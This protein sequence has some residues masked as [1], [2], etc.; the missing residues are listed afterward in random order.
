MRTSMHERRLDAI[1]KKIFFSAKTCAC[2][3]DTVKG[4]EMWFVNRWAGSG[5]CTWYYC[6]KCMKTKEDVLKQIDTDECIYGIAEVDPSYGFKSPAGPRP[7]FPPVRS[8]FSVS[9]LE[10]DA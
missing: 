4:E 7:P 10:N 8:K 5:A 3:K 1:K 2:C 9:I 6:T